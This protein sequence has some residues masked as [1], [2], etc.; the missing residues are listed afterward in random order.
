MSKQE[1]EDIFANKIEKLANQICELVAE[2]TDEAIM[3]ITEVRQEMDNLI[4]EYKKEKKNERI[5]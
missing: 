3:K 1:D 4:A 2:G 5:L